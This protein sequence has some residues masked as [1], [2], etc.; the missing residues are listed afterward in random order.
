MI[1]NVKQCDICGKKEGAELKSNDFINT[2]KTKIKLKNWK[3]EDISLS[4][5][6]KLHTT[7]NADNILNDSMNNY[8]QF[9]HL[10]EDENDFDY[11]IMGYGNFMKQQ[12]TVNN[13][14]LK[15]LQSSD[16]HICKHCYK[17]IIGLIQKFGKSNR[18]VKI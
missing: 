10:L 17:G 15:R 1:H 16:I 6:M 9:N 7:Q 14:I 11:N 3:G 13:A 4:L 2:D 5:S 8:S 18:T 12:M